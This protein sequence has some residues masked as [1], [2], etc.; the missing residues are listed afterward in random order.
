MPYKVAALRNPEAP[1]APH[2]VIK[3]GGTSIG[4]RY[5]GS[6]SIFEPLSNTF[7]TDRGGRRK[8]ATAP[9]IP[10]S[11]VLF[12]SAATSAGQHQLSTSP[13]LRFC[14]KS[15]GWRSVYIML[16]YRS[17]RKLEVPKSELYLYWKRLRWCCLITC[18][19]VDLQ[20]LPFP[21]GTWF[22]RRVWPGAHHG[23]QADPK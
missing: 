17:S 4:N 23:W 7:Y 13:A 1:W 11:L 18:S 20:I 12:L 10:S 3:A 5:C 15:N 16:P 2:L 6:F 22:R 14:L 9:A 21:F 8:S 19:R